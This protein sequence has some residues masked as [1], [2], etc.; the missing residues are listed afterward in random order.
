MLM[1]YFYALSEK[2]IGESRPVLAE[3]SGSG[4]GG[5]L[6][7]APHP[8]ELKDVMDRL[9]AKLRLQASSVAVDG[10]PN[11]KSARDLVGTPTTGYGQS[12]NVPSPPILMENNIM[13]PVPQHP[14]ETKSKKN[15][16]DSHMESRLVSTNPGGNNHQTPGGLVPDSTE[17]DAE[18]WQ[19]WMRM[20]DAI[21]IE[22]R[23]AAGPS[24]EIGSA[25]LTVFPRS[26]ADATTATSPT[27]S[28]GPRTPSDTSAVEFPQPSPLRACFST[29][30]LSTPE[31]G[32]FV[33]LFNTD[34]VSVVPWAENRDIMSKGHRKRSMSGLLTR[35]R[36]RPKEL[37]VKKSLASVD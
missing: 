27:T 2:A 5:D 36:P 33:E 13:L 25:S 8:A 17:D 34:G 9:I 30:L 12:S 22:E 23:S 6:V 26:S 14:L 24:S 19:L 1:N 7:Q 4:S 37:F 29:P 16:A 3:N 15:F 35:W 32:R 21:L 18:I 10:N 28:A 20:R 11:K 31:R